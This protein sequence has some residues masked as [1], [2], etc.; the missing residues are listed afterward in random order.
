MPT[1]SVGMAPKTLHLIEMRSIDADVVNDLHSAA[2][3]AVPAK[4]TGSL[5]AEWF[6]GNVGRNRG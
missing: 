5:A 2:N 3:M 1:A 4:F 6:I